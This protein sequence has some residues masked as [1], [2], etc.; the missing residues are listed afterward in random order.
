MKKITFLFAF[1]VFTYVKTFGSY[2]TVLV[3]YHKG[4]WT[5]GV[6]QDDKVL[7]EVT[8]P[9]DETY[10]YWARTVSCDGFGFTS[11]PKNSNASIALGQDLDWIGTIA[12]DLY[13]Y[14]WNRIDNYSETEGSTGSTYYNPTLNLYVPIMVEWEVNGDDVVITVSADFDNSYFGQ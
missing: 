10:I 8:L 1:V 3:S 13:D 9:N 2:P 6:V 11:C 4:C 12:I 5:C 14:S 7:C